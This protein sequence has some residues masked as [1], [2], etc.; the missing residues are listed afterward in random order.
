MIGLSACTFLLHFVNFCLH[1]RYLALGLGQLF[2]SLQRI[3][4]CGQLFGEDVFLPFQGLE[5]EAHD[6]ELILV[7]PQSSCNFG[8]C[9]QSLCFLWWEFCGWVLLGCSGI[10]LIFLHWCVCGFPLLWCHRGLVFELRTRWVPL[11]GSRLPYHPI[12]KHTQ[13]LGKTKRQRVAF[14]LARGQYILVGG[15]LYP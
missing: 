12:N 5:L 8:C 9:V 4:L 3:L 15:Y 14:V 11:L 7:G 13:R 6:G 1:G 2:C 10:I